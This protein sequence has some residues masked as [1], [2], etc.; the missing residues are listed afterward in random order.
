[1]DAAV[2]EALYTALFGM[3]GIFVAMGLIIGSAV[4]LKKIFKA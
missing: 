2:V 4:V 3:L 1:M